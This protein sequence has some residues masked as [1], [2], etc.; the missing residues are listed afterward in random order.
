MTQPFFM[1]WVYII[2]SPSADKFYVGSS[3][4]PEGRLLAH[5]HPQNNGWTKRHQPWKLVYTQSY[6]TKQEAEA[7][8]RK[9]KAFKSRKMIENII[10]SR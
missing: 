6:T 9:I 8:E 3:S 4:N 1:H 10:N 7:A 5:N 2:Y